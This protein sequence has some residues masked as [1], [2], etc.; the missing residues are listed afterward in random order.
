MYTMYSIGEENEKK[1]DYEALTVSMNYMCSVEPF[2]LGT[3]GDQWKYPLN[4]VE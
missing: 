3:I 4:K 1:Q 2:I